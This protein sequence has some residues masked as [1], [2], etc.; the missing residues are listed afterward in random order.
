MCRLGAIQS[1][2]SVARSNAHLLAVKHDRVDP[3]DHFKKY[4]GGYNLKGRH[5]LAVSLNIEI[6][7][8]FVLN[9][10]FSSREISSLS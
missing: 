7:H 5:Y 10:Q 1:S 2:H 8:L 3:L 4:R 9:R 6:V